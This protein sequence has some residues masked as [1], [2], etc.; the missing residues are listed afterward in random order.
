[1]KKNFFISLA[2]AATLFVSAQQKN[3]LLEQSF[4]KTAPDVNAVKAEIAK[5]NS[6]SASTPNAFDVTVMAINNDAP[7]ATIK[8]LLEQPGNEVT[9]STHDN[10]IYL[11]WAANKGNVEIVEYLIAKGSDINLEDSKGETPLTFAAVSGQPN[12]A[13]YDAFF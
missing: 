7:A 12:T 2:L 6:P 11:H 4:W 3:P 5:G 1:M 13:I 8:F 9:K 10:R